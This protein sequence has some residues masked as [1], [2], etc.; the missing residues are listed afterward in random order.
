[1]KRLL[2]PALSVA[3]GLLLAS[4]G[5][6]GGASS[7]DAEASGP[8]GVGPIHVHALGV[9]PAD[10]SLFA[11]THTGLFRVAEGE[12]E[13]SRVEDNYQDTMGFTVVGPNHFLGSGHPDGRADLPPFLGLIE[14]AV[15]GESWKP[16]SLLGRAD[17]HV[18]EAASERIYGFG[19]DFE[20]RCEQFLVSDDGGE[21]WQRREVP[22]SLLSLA[23]D[24]G[25]SDHLIASGRHTLFES[26]DAGES[27][28][29]MAGEPGLLSWPE[30]GA[31]YLVD[32]DGAVSVSP[33]TAQG[34]SG[35]GEI[36]GAP[37]AFEANSAE[38]LY[39]ATHDGAIVQSN[40]G[41]ATWE[42]RSKAGGT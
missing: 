17:F 15:A 24:P 26:A 28:D 38:A 6:D 31:L 8:N 2:V 34:W 18:L 19:S 40:D 25:D 20:T 22:E 5:G 37:A 9:N 27:W 30:A 39:A 4:C 1:M 29:P 10:Q 32:K 41:A 12:S 11:A 35:V 13:L 21:K 16:V 7:T 42:L 33:G 36:G 23:I 3:A 14:S